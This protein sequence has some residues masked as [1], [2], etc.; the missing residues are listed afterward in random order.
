MSTDSPLEAF[1]YK[2]KWDRSWR[3]MWSQGE[4]PRKRETGEH[5][6]GFLQLAWGWGVVTGAMS[7]DKERAQDPVSLGR[8]W[9]SEHSSLSRNAAEVKQ[10]GLKQ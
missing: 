8:S 3:G 10:M 5:I 4:S 6:L 9:V 2:E 1:C 7:S